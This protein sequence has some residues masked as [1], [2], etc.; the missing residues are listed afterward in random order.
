MTV[1]VRSQSPTHC[2]GAHRSQANCSLVKRGRPL[3]SSDEPRQPA[4]GKRLAA[5]LTTGAVLETRIRVGHLANRV[6]AHRT[7]QAVACVHI[8]AGSLLTLEFG[9]ALAD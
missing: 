3:P 5:G 8:Q 7:R 2:H 4:I 9:S 1:A 6:P